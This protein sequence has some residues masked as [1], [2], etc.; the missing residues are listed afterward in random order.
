M[1]R[2]SDDE[3]LVERVRIMWEEEGRT[4]TAIAAT[5][6]QGV[7]RNAIVGFVHRRGFRPRKPSQPPKDAP[8]RRPAI[9]RAIFRQRPPPRPAGSPEAIPETARPVRL[10]ALEPHHCRW[11]LGNVAGPETLFCGATTIDGSSYCPT[12]VDISSGHRWHE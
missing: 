4:A 6:G 8:K 12:H 11:I 10:M 7:T 5:I 3:A 2:W 9:P 1:S